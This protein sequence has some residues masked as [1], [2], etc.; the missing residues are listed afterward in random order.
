MIVDRYLLF[1]GDDFYPLGG[2]KDFKKSSNC[3]ISLKSISQ[4]MGCLEWAHIYDTK[5][6]K[7]ISETLEVLQIPFE[8]EYVWID[9]EL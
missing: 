4:K 8:V 5:R 2:M 6:G 3:L 9:N 1:H 7:I